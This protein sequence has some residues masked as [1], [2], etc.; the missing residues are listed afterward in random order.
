MPVVHNNIQTTESVSCEILSSL[1]V[2]YHAG[3]K[4]YFL[5][6][7]VS[8]HLKGDLTSIL[9]ISKAFLTETEKRKNHLQ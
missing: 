7:F 9:K 2:S 6:P 1:D 4:E 5:L 8:T 3:T